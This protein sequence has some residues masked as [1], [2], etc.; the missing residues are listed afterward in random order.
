MSSVQNIIP[1]N[2]TKN[3]FGGDSSEIDVFSVTNMNEE[4]VGDS[5]YFSNCSYLKTKLYIY[6]LIDDKI[7]DKILNIKLIRTHLHSNKKIF[8]IDVRYDKLK[9][10]T[11]FMIKTTDITFYKNIKDEIYSKYKSSKIHFCEGPAQAVTNIFGEDSLNVDT[12]CVTDMN[13]EGVGGSYYYC[14][15]SHSKTKSYIEIWIRNKIKHEKLNIKSTKT[16]LSSDKTMIFIV[17]KYDDKPKAYTKFMIKTM[18]T[19]HYDNLKFSNV[20][21]IN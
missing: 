18:E 12:F 20:S 9:A 14:S 19:F 21:V 11:E 15:C 1:D 5:N 8:I 13:E 6:S 3:I 7:K 4:G 10:Y 2:D 17:L 16:F